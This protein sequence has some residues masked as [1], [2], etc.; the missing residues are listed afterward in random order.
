MVPMDSK[1]HPGL[2]R[3]I[4]RVGTAAA[5]AR[6]LGITRQALGGWSE[7]PANRVREV[8]RVTGVPK[9]ELRPDLF[10]APGDAF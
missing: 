10:D 6:R 5:L 1:K 3:A 4:E 2:K 8:A 7:V 9:H